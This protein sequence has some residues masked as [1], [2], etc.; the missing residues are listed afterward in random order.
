ME[1][2]KRLFT[3]V[4]GNDKV[5]KDGE[6]ILY[7]LLVQGDP[8]Y[9]DANEFRDWLF[10]TGRQAA[11]DYIV[12]LLEND[13]EAEYDNFINIEESMIYADN[14]HIPENQNKLKLSNGFTFYQF[15]KDATVLNK[16]DVKEGFDIEEFRQQSLEDIY[17]DE[18]M[19][20]DDTT[21][22]EV[23]EEQ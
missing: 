13:H 8:K 15:I 20:E 14:P 10:I 9:E 4:D 16:V 22:D 21:G 2:K 11:Y 7:L 17:D 1:E 19:A 5:K 18:H 6:D 3:H 23:D 12:N